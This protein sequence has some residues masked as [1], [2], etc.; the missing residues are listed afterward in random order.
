MG[1]KRSTAK[2]GD[3]NEIKKTESEQGIRKGLKISLEFIL[4]AEENANPNIWTRLRAAI[5]VAVI[6]TVL[7]IAIFA[8]KYASGDSTL[9]DSLIKFSADNVSNQMLTSGRL[10]C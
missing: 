4:S 3:T 1:I 5:V 9:F 7:I 8:V 6:L 10:N 2:S